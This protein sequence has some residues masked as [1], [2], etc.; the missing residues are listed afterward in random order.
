MVVDR[1]ILLDEGIGRRYIGFRLVVIVVGDEILHRIVREE[2]L[3]LPIELGCQR[4]VWRKHQRGPLHVGDHVGDA[5]GLAGPRYTQQRLVRQA[6][7][8]AFDHLPNGF[9][10]V[11]GWLEARDQFELRHIDLFR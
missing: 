2:C 7:L 11:S 1:R 10:L 8:D 3:E 4:L 6:G 9:R 5:E